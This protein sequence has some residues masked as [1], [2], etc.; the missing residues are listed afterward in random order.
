M[1]L[2]A[3]ITANPQISDPNLIFPGDVLCIPSLAPPAP[4]GRRPAFCPSS[5]L[6]TVQPG[7]TMFLIAQRFGV[8]LGAL[9]L[10]NPQIS[11]PN[12]IF[13]GDVLCI[14]RKP[15]VCPSQNLYVVQPG[16]TMF[17]IAQRFGVT[18]EA[19]IAANPQISDPNLVF[20][21]DVLCIPVPVPVP[22]EVC[23]FL[24]SRTGDAPEKAAGV[25]WLRILSPVG[26]KAF[27]AGH[28]LKP[29]Q[30][31]GADFVAYKGKVA[32]G[33]QSLDV[34]MGKTTFTG[35]GEEIWAGFAEN[36]ALGPVIPGEAYVFPV[37]ADGTPGPVVLK[38][39][40]GPCV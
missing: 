6:Y 27:V 19:L 15:P 17:F 37:K 20:P 13:P 29:P 35:E 31:Y 4:P 11:D 8:P 16:D 10:A 39:F 24:L 9:I 7:D 26:L 32:F 28:H 2:E 30:D 1:T 25:L 5:Q 40:M 34:P 33:A 21:G 14:P 12:L 22:R 36:D 18:L 23:C 38:G 3:L